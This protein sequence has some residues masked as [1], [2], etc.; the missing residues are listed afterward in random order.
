MKYGHWTVLSEEKI[1][2]QNRVYLLCKCDCGTLRNVIVKNLKTGISSSCGCIGS[3]K[4]IDRNTKHGKRY[5]KIW[6]VWRAMKTRCYNKNIIQ[7]RD[8]GG[9]GIKVCDEWL[10]FENFYKDMGEAPD[11]LSLDRINNNGDYCKE[12]CRWS[13]VREQSRN[14]RSNRKINGVCISDISVNLGGKQSLVDKRLKRGWSTEK[15]TTTKS[16]A[17]SKN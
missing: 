15:A 4:I 16:N 13:S 9:R 10:N 8:Y 3:K 11:G 17:I 14:R 6:R 7:Y 5:T 2:F 12:N 1:V